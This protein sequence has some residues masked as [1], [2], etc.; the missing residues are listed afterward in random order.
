MFFKEK[1]PLTHI[2]LRI[3]R[4]SNSEEIPYWQDIDYTP[5]SENDT[6]AIAL[7]N[8]NNAKE[9]TDVEGNLVS[10]I[11][12]E[13][14]CLQ[15]KCGACAMVIDGRP[16]LACDALLSEYSHRKVLTI[17]PLR[18][19]PCIADLVVDRSSLHENL[20]RL[21][22]WSERKLA[23][24]DEN[25]DMSYESSRCLMC[26]CCLEV[27]PNFNFDEEFFGASSF[28]NATRYLV[29]MDEDERRSMRDPYVKHV[30]EGC[31]KSLSCKDICPAGI[32]TEKLLVKSNAIA[33]WRKKD[34]NRH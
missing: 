23:I 13:C 24:T 27:C 31:G 16:R 18:K 10:P 12:W 14:S 30:Y 32:D 11:K 25:I 22:L 17:Q 6:V 7:E 8:I 33:V 19:F 15:K 2:V 34:K 20:K 1:K 28:V 26:G 5:E 21:E 29:N 9:Y 3:L 4:R